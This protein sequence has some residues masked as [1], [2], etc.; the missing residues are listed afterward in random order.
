MGTYHARVST[1]G[2]FGGNPF[3]GMPFFSDL[4]KLFTSQGPVNW[5]VARQFAPQV[6]SAGQPEPNVE[7]LERIAYEELLRVADMH[8]ADVT[9]LDTST[10]GR[11]PTVRAVTRGEWAARTLDDWK[12]LFEGLGTSLGRTVVSGGDDEVASDLLGGLGQLLGPLL[13]GMQAGSMAGGLA[14]IALGQYDPPIPRPPSDELL[15]VPANVTDLASSVGVPIDDLRLWV[16]LSELTHHAVLARPHVR[17]RLTELLTDYVALFEPDMGA[18]E[19]RL[20][21][22]DPSDPTS[23]GAALGQDP[24]ALLGALRSPAQRMLLT[25]VSA[26]VAVVEGYVDHVVDVAAQRL[27]GDAAAVGAALHVRRA[28]EREHD[29]LVEGLFGLTLDEPTYE[30]GRGFVH[31]VLERAG[32]EGL[33][34]LWLSERELPTPAEVD[35]PGLWLAR[36]ELPEDDLELPDFPEDL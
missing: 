4:A 26:L 27:I 10:T 33:S 1:S 35:A 19:E 3:E 11:L 34:K 31:G 14:R 30:R 12:P 16:L 6:A 28:E 2:P 9:G 20:G 22:I 7:P 15:V 36:I 13:L 24:A 18:L 17:R 29:A 23:F 32:E 8:V 25:Q 5:Q 21:S